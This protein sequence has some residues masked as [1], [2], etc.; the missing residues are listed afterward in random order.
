MSLVPN[1]LMASNPKRHS[2]GELRH[3]QAVKR[4]RDPAQWTLLTGPLPYQLINP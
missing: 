3:W 2:G 4:Q 1:R